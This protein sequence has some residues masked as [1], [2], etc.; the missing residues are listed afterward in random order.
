[1]AVFVG[2]DCEGWCLW[3][4]EGGYGELLVVV[5]VGWG[6]VGCCLLGVGKGNVLAGISHNISRTP[7]IAGTVFT[8]EMCLI[9]LL[10]RIM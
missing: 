5:F 4:S 6:C 9:L 1:M 7:R 10:S 3:G 8:R 2:W